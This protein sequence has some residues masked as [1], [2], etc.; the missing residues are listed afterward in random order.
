MH[1]LSNLLLENGFDPVLH[2]RTRESLRAGNIGLAANRL[3]SLAAF[4]DVGP[5]HVAHAQRDV[6]SQCRHLG[7]M[8]LAD[9]EVAVLTL[10]GG[11]GSRWSRGT[12]SVKAL[13]A[14]QELGGHERSFLEIHLAKSLCTLNQCGTPLPHV[15]ATSY[16]T[17]EPIERHL[18]RHDLFGYGGPVALS[19]GYSVG[20][21]L[22]PPVR[23]LLY[24]WS[25]RRDSWPD[26]DT[27]TYRQQVVEWARHAG[28]ASEYTH[29]TPLQCLY[30]L[31]HWFEFANLLRNGTLKVLLEVR[32]QLQ[33]L[34]LHN[35]DTLGAD[36]DPG[37][38]G[39]HIRHDADLTFELVRRAPTDRGG[40]LARVN[41]H[42]R[43]V[44]G[45]ALPDRVR[46]NY[47]SYYNTMTTWITIDRLLK[48]F[49]LRRDQLGDQNAVDRAV[50][51][52]ADRVP[53]YVTLKDVRKHGGAGPD[54]LMPVAQCEKLWGD[55]SALPELDC[56]YVEVPRQR[57]QQLKEPA[58]L[59]DWRQ[60]GS[61]QHVAAL[62]AWQ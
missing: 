62:C 21:R 41:G 55:M 38:L 36:V 23:D 58:Q 22:V 7:Q 12:G 49:G 61:A 48:L 42:V 2:E 9:G 5:D 37:L 35:I 20:W 10:A 40:G 43:L 50:R 57:G 51:R 29:N 24:A 3:S 25:Q 17:H 6:D 28:P 39:W 47:L 4:E 32:P 11:V 14:F 8:S 34:M 15:I 56:H 54:E 18:D 13:Y 26:P 46:E 44:E 16:L 30:P 60:D 53:T 45:L 59:D 19:R 33:Y 27:R 52:I 31:G 1:S